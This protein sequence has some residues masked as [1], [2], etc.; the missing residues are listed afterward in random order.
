M[1]TPLSGETIKYLNYWSRSTLVRG[2][3][4]RLI[5]IRGIG[6]ILIIRLWVSSIYMLKV[7]FN[8]RPP[9]YV[10]KIFGFSRV[11]IFFVVFGRKE[12]LHLS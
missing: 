6:F 11:Y 12:I 7:K 10:L 2:S 4:H 1:K 3:S 5:C 9:R 8:G